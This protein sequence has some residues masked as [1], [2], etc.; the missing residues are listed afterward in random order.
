MVEF[1]S[2]FVRSWWPL[3]CTCF[4][5]RQAALR[6]L[7]LFWQLLCVE[8]FAGVP[9]RG[10]P[11]FVRNVVCLCIICFHFPPVFEG[12]QL[13]VCCCLQEAFGVLTYTSLSNLQKQNSHLDQDLE[14]VP[15]LEMLRSGFFS[16][17]VTTAPQTAVW[18]FCPT[19]H[20][21]TL[22]PIHLPSNRQLWIDCG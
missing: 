11:L 10:D 7:P 19:S 17:E 1:F 2:L 16:L 21:W 4:E 9:L 13:A 8:R 20:Q 6:C 3:I 14:Q 12:V 5:H 15:P 22:L 18:L